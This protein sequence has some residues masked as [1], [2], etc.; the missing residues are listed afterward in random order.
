MNTLERVG[1]GL[2]AAELLAH[3]ERE[4]VKGPCADRVN[5]AWN[6]NERAREHWT[7]KAAEILAAAPGID[8]GAMT[9]KPAHP[10]LLACGTKD[11][12]TR[13]ERIIDLLTLA[14]A[15]TIVGVAGVIIGIKTAL[16]EMPFFQ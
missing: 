12:R 14:T 3:A 7:K 9:G 2:F 13:A 4:G 8:L 6:Q 5:R 16:G 11:A 1:K 10:F 15:M